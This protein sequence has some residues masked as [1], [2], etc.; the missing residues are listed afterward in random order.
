[1]SEEKVEQPKSALPKGC[2]GCAG[3]MFA[4]VIVFFVIAIANRK[5]PEEAANSADSGAIVACRNYV[6]NQLKAPATA[7]FESVLDGIKTW[8]L[9]GGKYKVSSYVDSQNGFGAKVRTKFGCY[10]ETTDG[11]NFTVTNL[12]TY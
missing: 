9:G 4:C 3:L 6:R 10:A 2:L 7:D 12:E 8:N 1:M 5:S 11:Q